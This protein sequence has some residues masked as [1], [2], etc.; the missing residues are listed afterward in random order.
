M[1]YTREDYLNHKCSHRE[2]YAQFVNDAVKSMVTSSIPLAEL[3]AAT[4]KENLNSIAL[5][6]WDNIAGGYST[7]LCRDKLKAAGDSPSLGGAV[8]I[9]KEA[10]RQIIDEHSA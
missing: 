2:Y 1:K 9:L 8:C 6:R 5:A 7:Q 4:D 3:L 10:A